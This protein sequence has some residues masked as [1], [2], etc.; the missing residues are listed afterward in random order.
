MATVTDT[1]GC[2]CWL[3]ETVWPDVELGVGGPAEEPPQQPGLSLAVW[4]ERTGGS[5]T[6][7]GKTER[8]RRPP[9]NA[10]QPKN[11]EVTKR[12][13][14]D[15]LLEDK[16]TVSLACIW[17]ECASS[18]PQVF[19]ISRTSSNSNCSDFRA[20]VLLWPALVT[21]CGKFVL[22]SICLH[23]NNQLKLQ[24]PLQFCSQVHQTSTRLHS[25]KA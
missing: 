23:I 11:S 6:L 1:E 15:P 20:K 9:E 19:V 4:L 17:S 18:L 14:V 25:P 16:A 12:S 2:V 8:T 24:G 3:R 10:R 5:K 22:N 21:G 13:S 7:R